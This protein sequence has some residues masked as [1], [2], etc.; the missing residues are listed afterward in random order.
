M[1]QQIRENYNQLSTLNKRV[2]L[3]LFLFFDSLFLGLSYG[4]GGLNFLDIILL[5]KLPTDL[6]WLLQILESISAG[7]L[8]IKI[9]FD[10][11]PQV[12]LGHW[13]YFSLLY[14]C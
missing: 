4:Y 9:L 1:L 6:I 10:D 13:E 5:D 11:I 7:F 14:S 12:E 8:V 3:A 2:F